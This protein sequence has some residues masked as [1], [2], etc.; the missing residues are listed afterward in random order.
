MTSDEDSTV[1]MEVRMTATDRSSAVA[2]RVTLE[3]DSS[4]SS[5]FEAADPRFESTSGD[6]DPNDAAQDA[7]SDEDDD[8]Q[9]EASER[10]GDAYE[11]DRSI[12]KKRSTND[13]NGP[14]KKRKSSRMLNR[15]EQA[16]LLQLLRDGKTLV[17]VAARFDVSVSYVGRLK[18]RAKEAKM[19]LPFRGKVCIKRFRVSRKSCCMLA[20]PSIDRTRRPNLVRSGHRRPPH[21]HQETTTIPIAWSSWMIRR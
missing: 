18:K 13:A 5:D 2:E 7:R 6:D 4:S 19:D 21:P 1:E 14:R 16:Q 15:D 8:H 10:H 11:G 20:D 3:L 17:A 12:G 9:N